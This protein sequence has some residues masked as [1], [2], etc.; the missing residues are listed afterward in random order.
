MLELFPPDKREKIIKEGS[1]DLLVSAFLSLAEEVLEHR[2]ENQKEDEES[3]LASEETP[4]IPLATHNYS[5][6]KS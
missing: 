5:F 6:K 4:S 1:L 2:K 3:E